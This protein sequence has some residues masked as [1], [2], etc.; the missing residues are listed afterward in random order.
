[1]KSPILT[2]DFLFYFY[3]TAIPVQEKQCH[4]KNENE[5]S[6]FVYFL[7]IYEEIF[8]VISSVITYPCEAIT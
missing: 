2:L 3:N 5:V 7:F 1:M 8:T 6:L 4:V